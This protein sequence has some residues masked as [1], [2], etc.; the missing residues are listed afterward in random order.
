MDSV[1]QPSSLTAIVRTPDGVH[2]TREQIITIK[3]LA[4]IPD[5]TALHVYYNNSTERQAARISYLQRLDAVRTTILNAIEAHRRQPGYEELDAVNRLQKLEE[6]LPQIHEHHFNF[7]SALKKL[8]MQQDAFMNFLIECRAALMDAF[9]LSEAE[10]NKL[11]A[12][13]EEYALINGVPKPILITV[14]PVNDNLL[15]QME[16]PQA[17]LSDEQLLEFFR[18]KPKHSDQP[19]WYKLMPKN[20]KRFF[21]AMMR[22]ITSVSEL[23]SKMHAISS[24]HRTIPGVANFLKHEL[25]IVA[26]TGELLYHP[27]CRYRSSMV[28]SRDLQKYKGDLS[29]L[30]LKTTKDNIQKII[31]TAIDDIL[32]D[33]NRRHL[34]LNTGGE[35]DLEIVAAL[36]ILLQTLISPSRLASAAMPDYDLF[37]DKNNAIAAIIKSGLTINLDGR[38]IP[39]RFSNIIATN[40][41]LNKLGRLLIGMDGKEDAIKLIALAKKS[42]APDSPAVQ[43]ANELST[44]IEIGLV[45]NLTADNQLQ[46]HMAALEEFITTRLG[47]ISYGSCV[48]GKDRKG[49]ETIYT[50][51]MEIYFHLRGRLP[52]YDDNTLSPEERRIF[53][54]I[55]A[56]LFVTRHQQ[57]SAGLNALGADGIKT[58]A[59]YLPE[60]IQLA[61]NKRNPTLLAESDRLASNNE[62]NKLLE[63]GKHSKHLHTSRTPSP[64]LLTQNAFS[65]VQ[66]QQLITSSFWTDK[67]TGYTPTHILNMRRLFSQTTLSDDT[68][69]T[70]LA[71]YCESCLSQKPSELRSSESRFV[72]DA[73]LYLRNNV[74][75]SASLARNHFVFYDRP[76]NIISI[77]AEIVHR[78]VWNV[79]DAK[80]FGSKTPEGIQTIRDLLKTR[81]T[82]FQ[83]DPYGLLHEIANTCKDRMSV[84]SSPSSL[85]RNK[86]TIKLYKAIIEATTQLHAPGDIAVP[87][88]AILSSLQSEMPTE[89]KKAS[90]PQST[91][92]Q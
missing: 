82:T 41:P 30:R 50:D 2:L 63:K 48:S 69:K 42:L 54:E 70:A 25:G 21:D 86:E 57:N 87:L 59:L 43:A 35:I 67:D 85:F 1:T 12:I 11:L 44:L 36:P 7:I 64:E 53:V 39:I 6:A 66:L 46:L 22:D 62:L 61:I 73:L 60:D 49:L 16:I 90:G 5:G 23:K 75:G 4:G 15:V 9:K 55:F 56:D 18:A 89:S 31:Q 51:A 68:L 58:P 92:H 45:K 19:L 13:G 83:N 81:A 33:P 10:A 3:R 52:R 28:S 24:K 77:I 29:Q 72:L 40:H 65:L 88:N 14:S 20:E 78:D 80:L 74:A 37:V 76:R 84:F 38:S 27:P 8:S 91:H 17:P 26:A 32:K 34:I 71:D 47:G 79:S